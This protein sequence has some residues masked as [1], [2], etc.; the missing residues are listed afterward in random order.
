MI[1]MWDSQD[2]W[3]DNFV[4]MYNWPDAPNYSCFRIYLQF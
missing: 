1:A 2:F 3:Y 4:V